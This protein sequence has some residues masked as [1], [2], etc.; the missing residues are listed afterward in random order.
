MH[1][2]DRGSNNESLGEPLGEPVRQSSVGADDFAVVVPVK[3]SDH[4]S[5]RVAFR[6]DEGPGRGIGT[7]A[8]AVEKSK[9]FT[10]REPVEPPEP[11]AVETRRNLGAND[12]PFCCAIDK[13]K[14][15]PE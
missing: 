12:E 10:E 2:T 13:A 4:K 7:N 9:L 8:Q 11:V 15:E 14:H 6:G 5:V 1:D 3:L